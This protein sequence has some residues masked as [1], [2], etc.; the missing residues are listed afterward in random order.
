MT[1]IFFMYFYTGIWELNITTENTEKINTQRA[2]CPQP[3]P[4]LFYIFLFLS[5]MCVRR[6]R[7]KDVAEGNLG[8]VKR[9]LLSAVRRSSKIIIFSF[10]LLK[11]SL[12]ITACEILLLGPSPLAT[13]TDTL[14]SSA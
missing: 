7:I 6:F 5:A 12:C 8:E 11:Y 4:Y 1:R 10:Y 14:P 2:Q 3:H 9:S 13:L